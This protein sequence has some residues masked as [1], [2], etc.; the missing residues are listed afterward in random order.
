MQRQIEKKVAAWLLLASGVA[1]LLVVGGLLGLWLSG[2]FASKSVLSADRVIAHHISLV[3]DKG[4]LK[5]E[6]K[7]D[8]DE[9]SLI[10]YD[11]AQH[12]RLSLALGEGGIA[13]LALGRD[14]KDKILLTVNDNLNTSSIFISATTGGINLVGTNEAQIK[15]SDSLT[16]DARSASLGLGS[17]VTKLQLSSEGSEAQL[18]AKIEPSSLQMEQRDRKVE[19]NMRTDTKPAVRL[20]VNSEEKPILQLGDSETK[21]SA[22]PRRK[23]GH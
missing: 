2:V 20:S 5:A 17:G 11:K 18:M 19:L 15:I 12:E 23:I 14:K 16:T 21:I 13:I 4:Q 8:G 10:F 7:S 9:S 3:D 6:L 1:G 22:A